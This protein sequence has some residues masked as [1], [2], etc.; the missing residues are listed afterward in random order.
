MAEPE[1][2]PEPVPPEPE[3]HDPDPEVEPPAAEPEPAARVVTAAEAGRPGYEPRPLVIPFEGGDGTEL[4][5]RFL[6]EADRAQADM[7]TQLVVVI[8]SVQDGREMEC[9]S[10]IVPES[11]NETVE[12]P[13]HTE[14]I[15]VKRPVTR[16]VSES[17]YRCHSVQQSEM[18]PRTDYQ[19][20]CRSVSRPV[21]KTRTVY[22]P[23]Y[24]SH[25]RS[26]RSAP[27]TETYTAYESR[28]ECTNRPVTRMESRLVS[29]RQCGFEPVSRLVTRYEFQYQS[30][31]VPPEL[32]SIT[33]QRL[34]EL[35]PVCL[36]VGGDGAAP[37]GNRIEG[38]IHVRASHPVVEPGRRPVTAP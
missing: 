17:Q 25:S 12:V 33:R 26:Y 35:D 2:E 9:R 30:R 3:P 7:V 27:Q 28:Y 32:T 19:R 1:P 22:R 37:R 20:D 21:S 14:Q 13:G 15:P 6:A 31:Y 16:M 24:D 23:Q 18:H 11:Y 34:R 5:T 29:R 10:G 4:V 36:A 8:G 38:V